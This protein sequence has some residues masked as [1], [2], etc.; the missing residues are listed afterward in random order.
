MCSRYAAIAVLA[1]EARRKATSATDGGA[2]AGRAAGVWTG[3]WQRFGGWRRRRPDVY[4]FA[5]NLQRH[6]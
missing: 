3:R 5:E 4:S 2:V 1:V 6:G